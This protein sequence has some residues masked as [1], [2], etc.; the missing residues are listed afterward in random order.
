VAFGGR[1]VQ[2]RGDVDSAA[3]DAARA[4]TLAR[5]ADDAHAAARHAAAAA[6]GDGTALCA[7]LAVDVDTSAFRPGGHVTVSVMCRLQLADLALL[8]IPGVR[9]LTGRSTSTVDRHRGID[10]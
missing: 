1:L 4:A 7:S 8:G 10:P 2:A 5:S 9:T 6:L 3:R